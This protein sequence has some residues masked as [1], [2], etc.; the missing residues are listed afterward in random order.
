M[1]V[2]EGHGRDRSAGDCCGRLPCDLG[3]SD[4]QLNLGLFSHLTDALDHLALTKVNA[5]LLEF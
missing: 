1:R 4:Q 3:L 2:A 5:Q